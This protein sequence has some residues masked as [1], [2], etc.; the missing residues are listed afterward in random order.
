M[1]PC[2]LIP[3]AVY[4]RGYCVLTADR[5]SSSSSSVRISRI[6]GRYNMKIKDKNITQSDKREPVFD[7]IKSMTKAE[8]RSFKLYATRLA[9]NQEAKFLSLF[10]YLDSVDEYDEAKVL[11][12]CPVTKSQLPNMKAHLYKQLLVSI[13]LLDVQ[14]SDAFQLREQL[15]FARILYDKGLYKQSDKMLEKV[16]EQAFALEEHTIAIDA[17]HFQSKIDTL[18]VTRDMTQTSDMASRQVIGLAEEISSAGELSNLSTRAYSLYQKLGYARS[19]KDLDL[20]VL[21]FKPKLESFDE[22]KL[23]FVGKSHYYQAWAWYYYIQHDFVRS[24]RYS[25]KWTELFDSKP[26]MK[27]VM[28]DDYMKGAAQILEALYL[29][30]KYKHFSDNLEHFE[31]E[32][33]E[34]ALLNQ[35]ATLIGKRLYYINKINKFFIEGEFEQ[36]LLLV[37]EVESFVRKYSRDLNIHHKML[38]AYKIA[39]LY[40]GDGNYTKCMEY[41]SRITSTKDPQIRRDLQCFARILNLIASYE[42]GIDYNLDYQIRSVYSFLVKMNDM[43]PVQKEMLTFLKKLN[44]IYA[45]DVKNELKVLYNRL[46]PYENRT[47]E[48]RAFYYLDLLSWLESKITGKSVA[49]IVRRKF[50]ELSA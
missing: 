19:Q 23:S 3:L 8:K 38:I 11:H 16:I 47:Y 48:R 40:F 45:D 28:Y 12:K 21:Y 31:K 24:Y 4:S 18:N 37:R 20:I 6:F 36:G 50:R 14:H 39:C 35:N 7:L 41:L 29:M 5:D 25:R 22:K 10:D 43:G 33:E 32:F 2:H 17:V 49:D 15:D 42:A 1:F 34:L 9:G 44:S 13:R 46:K 30:R 27:R 26:R